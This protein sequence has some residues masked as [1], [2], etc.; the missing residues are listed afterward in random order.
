MLDQSPKF[1][2]LIISHEPLVRTGLSSLLEDEPS[3][4]LVGQVGPGP[5]LEDTVSVLNPDLIL[6]DLGWE[7]SSGEEDA[8]QN[9]LEQISELSAEGLS[10]VVL[11]SSPDSARD[12]WI[13]GAR[14][15]LLRDVS[16]NSLRAVLMATV[17]EL[18]VL[19]A[20]VSA[21]L[22]PELGLPDR[23]PTEDLTPRELQVLQQLAEGSP[24]KTIAIKLD[25]SEH[26]V[27]FHIN[28]IF[29]KLSVRSRT[30]AVVR[31]SQLGL[32]LL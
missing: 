8:S 32:I 27:K 20:S 2:L 7:T 18:V 5:D 11:I 25:V 1:S 15:I 28:S 16:L 9:E 17:N 19:D 13:A 23:L 14:A 26:T 30:E 3:I 21:H 12:A 24:N 10:I 4:A 22:L 31:G 6:W 29:R